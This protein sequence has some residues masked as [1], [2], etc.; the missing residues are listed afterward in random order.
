MSLV[1]ECARRIRSQIIQI[2]QHRSV[3]V[4]VGRRWATARDALRSATADAT[5]EV[6]TRSLGALG[7]GIDGLERA[8][9]HLS[10]ALDH[11]AAYGPALG[12]DLTVGSG[13]NRSPTVTAPAPADRTVWIRRAGDSLP[14]RRG[15]V[16]PTHG[17]LFDP[18]GTEMTDPQLTH[19]SG[20]LRSGT[21]SDARAGLRPDWYPTA[22]VIREHV[23]PHAAA[24]LR[25][26]G[27][28]KEAV[29]VVNNWPCETVERY[30]GCDEVLPG[31]LPTGKRLVVFVN[32]GQQTRLFGIY[33]GTGEG[34]AS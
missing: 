13:D 29:L 1:Q 28:P 33:H 2:E 14:P 8:V 20:Y 22:Q 12:M 10:G 19:P 15:G 27:S 11:I 18:S 32:D 16:G 23:E 34:L 9:A 5:S 4:Q 25:R 30:V 24:I 3:L 6:I 26:P 7:D 31:L 17:R 21:V